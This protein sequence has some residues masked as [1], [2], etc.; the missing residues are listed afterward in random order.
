MKNNVACVK[1]WGTV[2][3]YLYQGKNGI[4]GFQYALC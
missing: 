2:V 4:V 3:G 1:L